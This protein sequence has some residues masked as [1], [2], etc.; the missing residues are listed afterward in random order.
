MNRPIDYRLKTL[1]QLFEA[2]SFE[3]SR[4]NKED[5][6][7]TK[8]YIKNEILTRVNESFKMLEDGE[9]PEYVLERL[10]NY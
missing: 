9:S 6:S 4:Y 1:K 7:V 3:N 10:T 8:E 2:Y 5:A